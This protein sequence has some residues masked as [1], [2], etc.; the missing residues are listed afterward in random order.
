MIIA[1]QF[2]TNDKTKKEKEILCQKLKKKKNTFNII[3]LYN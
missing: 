2:R 3:R 1:P